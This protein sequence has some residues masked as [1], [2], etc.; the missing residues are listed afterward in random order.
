MTWSQGEQ[1]ARDSDGARLATPAPSFVGVPS[2]LT[3]ALAQVRSSRA[4]ERGLH[5][6]DGREREQF[7][8]WHDVRQRAAAA[9]ARLRARGVER[10]DRV[11]MLFTTGPSFF[12]AFFGALWLGAVPAP[13]YPPVRLG[14]MP[15]YDRRT[16]V[17]LERSGARLVVVEPRVDRLLGGVRAAVDPELGFEPWIELEQGGSGGSVPAPAPVDSEDLALVQFSSGTTDRPKAVALSH[18]ALLHQASILAGHWP[19]TDE[20]EHAGASWLPL[21]HDMGLVGCVL[22]ALLR[23]ADLW[24]MAPELFIAKPALWLRMLSRSGAS[25]SPA[26][27]FAYAL[28][29]DRVRDDDLE[30]VD[31]SR[32]IAALNGAETVSMRTVERFAERFTPYGFRAESMTPVY[33]MSEAALAVT[34]APLEARPRAVPVAYG[35]EETRVGLGDGSDATIEVVSVG[36]PVPGFEVEVRSRDEASAREVLACGRVGEIWVRGPS[37]LRGMLRADGTT[38][39]VLEEGWLATGDLGFVQDGELF[40]TGRKKDVLILRG[41]NLAPDP[42]EDAVSSVPGVRTGC[43]VAVSAPPSELVSRTGRAGRSPASS[44]GGEGLWVLA[45]TREPADTLDELGDRCRDA[46]RV[47]TGLEISRLDFVAPG[48]LPRTSSGKLRRGA[49]RE[50]AVVGRLQA[51]ADTSLVDR[52]RRQRPVEAGLALL[53]SRR[54][55][56]DAEG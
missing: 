51:A 32:W 27:D 26:P 12:E 15:D 34:F 53:H 25:V 33:G 11:G 9:A 20:R 40:L 23:T 2:T 31:L 4:A 49:T 46:V 38:E 14:K 7:V 52:L 24:L 55:E 45:E 47:A 43:V 28:C 22:P 29:A 41:R 48:E 39:D 36:R 3:D 16:A 8:S 44:A 21:Y 1:G 17:M 18:R 10:G 30:G 54:A 42:V 50:Q 37:L 56:R 6:I 35:A 13:L 19:D 5:F